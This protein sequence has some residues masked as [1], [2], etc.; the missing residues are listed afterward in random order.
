MNTDGTGF[1][2]CNERHKTESLWNH[3][4]TDRKEG[5]Q[6]ED[7]RSVGESSCNCG[8]GTDRR[9]QSL[10]F[11]MM[12]MMI[13]MMTTKLT[14]RGT[15]DTLPNSESP[16]EAQDCWVG[17]NSCNCGDAADQKFQSLLFVMMELQRHIFYIVLC[18]C[19]WYESDG[20]GTSVSELQLN[21]RT[22]RRMGKWRYSST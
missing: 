8:D 17:V 4:A 21:I 18:I 6:L 11:M 20:K 12:M 15:E 13:M 10:M 1:H 22:W 9:V 3:T 16:E 19:N 2:T 7:R 14:Q 5:E